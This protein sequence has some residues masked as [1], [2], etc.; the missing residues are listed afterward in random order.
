M[1]TL[2]VSETDPRGPKAVELARD[3]GQWAT[4]RTRDGR[5][6]YGIRSSDGSRYYLVNRHSCT[7]PDFLHGR[8]R[9][10]KHVLA[11]ELHCQLVEEQTQPKLDPAPES[12]DD[13][14]KRFDYDED[15]ALTRILG[16]P[17]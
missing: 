2:L 17:R 14:F 13:I 6:F 15:R 4:C 12:A 1:S 10:C 5:K 9:D 16:R 8:G 7:C 11:V 3:A